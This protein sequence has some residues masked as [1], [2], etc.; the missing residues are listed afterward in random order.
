MPSFDTPWRAVVHQHRGRQA[1]AAKGVDERRAHG[2]AALVGA[3]LKHQRE[4]RMVVEHGQRMAAGAGEE[5]EV[6]L[7][8]H[9]PELVGC[10]ALEALKGTW[11]RHTLTEQTMAA[12]DSGDRTRREFGPALAK[13]PSRELASAPRTEHFAAHSDHLL[14][15]I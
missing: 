3:G 8:V 1:V 4:A 15:D 14:L 11:R 2:F 6:A 7:E 5:R 12:Q 9:L 10:C 13:Q